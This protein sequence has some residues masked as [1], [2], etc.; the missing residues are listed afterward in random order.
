MKIATILLLVLGLFAACSW[1]PSRENPVD[2]HSSNYISP[3]QG[4]HPPVI[5][6]LFRTTECRESW[7]VEFCSF[8]LICHVSDLDQNLVFDS[9]RAALRLDTSWLDLGGMS[10]NAQD[11][12]FILHRS[13]NEM[14]NGNLDEYV[15]HLLRV[16][17]Q[18]DSGA[19]DVSSIT[20]EDLS[21][22]YPTIVH[23]KSTWDSVHTVHPQL[24]WATWT[25]PQPFTYAV[26]VFDQNIFPVWDV[27]GLLSS[28]TCVTVT[29]SLRVADVFLSD[30]YT[31][32][33]TV[34]DG[35]GNRMTAR[36]GIFQVT[37]PLQP[38]SGCETIR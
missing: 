6:T 19:T 32:Y 35:R 20:F 4:N 37:R 33:L 34:V 36:P 31:W 27:S 26:A 38:S 3:P 7:S 2:P 16:T 24:G 9:V 8:T 25:G 28:D 14:P 1:S 10:Y 22:R 18:D 30:Q 12:N 23:P 13:Q 11:G 17:V 29:E 5:D 21:K 15:G